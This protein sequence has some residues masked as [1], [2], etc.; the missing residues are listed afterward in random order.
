MGHGSV[1]DMKGMFQNAPAFNADISAWNT[2][3]VTNELYV[4]GDVVQH[5]HLSWD[6]SSV[7]SM[8]GMFEHAKSFSA[9][10]CVE[11]ELRDDMY[12]MFG[13]ATAFNAD[14]SAWDTSSVTSMM[15]MFMGARSTRIYL[16][17]TSSVTNMYEMFSGAFNADICVGH[18]SV[19]SSV[20]VYWGD[21]VVGFVYTLRWWY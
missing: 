11:H 4:L 17:D 5:E 8:A 7:T 20:H 2:S 21:S 13:G 19:T 16:W 10:L 3:S 15:Y 18:N 9:H 14:I 6:T 1:T 12:L